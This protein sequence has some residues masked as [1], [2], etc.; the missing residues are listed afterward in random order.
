MYTYRLDS[1]DDESNSVDWSI[2]PYSSNGALPIV[3]NN[4]DM[5]SHKIEIYWAYPKM[6]NG[7]MP[8]GS[9]KVSNHGYENYVDSISVV[10]LSLYGV[11]V[12]LLHLFS[13]AMGWDFHSKHKDKDTTDVFY[14]STSTIRLFADSMRYYPNSSIELSTFQWVLPTGWKTADNKS[15]TFYDDAEIFVIPDC[16]TSG[17]IKVRPMDV[18]CQNESIDS[19]NGQFLSLYVKRTPSI[20][21]SSSHQ[22]I[23]KG[24]PATITLTATNVSSADSL[25]WHIVDGSNIKDT[26]TTAST[27]T[28][29]VSGCN[30][31]SYTVNG[32][33]CGKLN[34]VPA[35]GTISVQ[36]PLLPN[37]I[38][39]D[40]AFTATTCGATYTVSNLPP[41]LSNAYWTVSGGLTLL[42]SNTSSCS[43][44]RTSNSTSTSG[45]V[46]FHYTD[47]CTGQ[48]K[49]VSKQLVARLEP[50]FY[51]YKGYNAQNWNGLTAGDEVYF[52]SQTYPPEAISNYSWALKTPQSGNM[53]QTFGA[54]GGEL[55]EL[56]D[57][58]FERPHDSNVVINPPIGGGITSPCPTGFGTLLFTGRNTSNQKTV[59][60][61][62]TNH[63]TLTIT[64][65]CG[66]TRACQQ[67]TVQ[68]ATLPY[69]VSPNPASDFVNFTLQEL[70]TNFQNTNINTFAAS[71]P[72][73][74]N[75]ITVQLFSV[76]TGNLV[77]QQ[78]VSA[79]NQNFSLNL[80]NI[81]AGL[82]IV[83]II[84][85]NEIIQIS[86]ISINN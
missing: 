18:H 20:S 78:N 85:D 12:P 59:L 10:L 44:T 39:P 40:A 47:G 22:T 67:F 75:I 1:L 60:V 17:E 65:G 30:S 55:I 26:V 38:G 82:Y 71:S 62:G 14:N 80:Q 32:F 29:N 27:L 81:Q 63:L 53:M 64:D 58:P 42:S 15:G 69:L 51:I 2:K 86:T 54:I 6:Q 33:Y 70:S 43:I 24:I 9:I 61:A 45:S 21:I 35:K 13:S 16:V 49:T 28:F 57:R 56:P 5:D 73:S 77:L 72:T 79:S 8:K 74:P 48:A 11:K 50:I 83:H 34:N 41:N 37:I 7:K 66:V 23:P 52:Y 46:I 3:T 36:A 84:K 76:M 31:V 19:L 4:P 68:Q 25:K